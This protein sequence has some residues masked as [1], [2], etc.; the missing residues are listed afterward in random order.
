MAKEERANVSLGGSTDHTS[1]ARVGVAHRAGIISPEALGIFWGLG[2]AH[3]LPIL[4]AGKFDCFR[5]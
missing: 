4:V 5:G 3:T 1:R 2:K